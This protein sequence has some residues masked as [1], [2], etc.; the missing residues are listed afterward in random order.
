MNIYEIM[1][2]C[3]QI[4]IVKLDVIKLRVNIQTCVNR[5]ITTDINMRS[6][7]INLKA[8]M[9]CCVSTLQCY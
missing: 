5:E 3:S 9:V 1:L 6:M 8:A 2:L 7:Y 4:N